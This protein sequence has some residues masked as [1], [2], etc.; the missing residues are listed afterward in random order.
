M[1]AYNRKYLRN[2]VYLSLYTSAVMMQD[3]KN[4]GIAV[5]IV[6]PSWVQAELYTLFYMHFWLQAAI[7][8]FTLTPTHGSV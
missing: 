7:F 5:G 8:D 6:M 3:L 4:I 1:A 2:D